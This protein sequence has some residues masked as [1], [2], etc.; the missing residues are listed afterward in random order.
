MASHGAHS[1]TGLTAACVAPVPEQCT[2][3]L[4]VPNV[5]LGTCSGYNGFKEAAV[6]HWRPRERK[7]A[8][9]DMLR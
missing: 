2:T 3:I 1:P 6:E 5:L 9:R 4:D 8:P 7:S